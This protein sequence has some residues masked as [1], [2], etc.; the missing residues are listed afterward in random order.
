[1]PTTLTKKPLKSRIRAGDWPWLSPWL[2]IG[3][4]SLL[5]VILT[6]IAF[7]NLHRERRYM[8]T[9]LSA[10]AH[11]LM[12][13]LEAA[14]RT[15]MMGRMGWG[16]NLLQMLMEQ[17]AQEPHV[18]YLR[19]VDRKG[20]V[21]LSSNPQEAGQEMP[22]QSP[23]EAGGHAFSDFQGKKAFEVSRPYEPWAR[24]TVTG[25]G[26]C[27]EDR[28]GPGT[29]MGRG[30]AGERANLFPEAGP[31]RLVV[32]LDATPL[33][34]ALRQDLAHNA[35]LLSIL[36]LL[37]ATGLIALFWAHGY[38]LA[39]QSLRTMQVMTEAIFARMPVGLIATD[40]HGIIRRTNPAARSLLGSRVAPGQRLT[41]LPA[42]ES[43]RHRLQNGEDPI[44]DNIV[45]DSER[46]RPLPLL[47]HATAIKDP[48]GD[49]A[50]FA[51]LLSDMTA[52]H[53]LEQKLRRHERLAALGKLA[54]GVAHEIRNPLSS[55]KGFAAIL[56]RKAGDDPT[57]QDVARTMTHE[58]D[59][60]NRVISEL[61]EFARPAELDPK[62]VRLRDIIQH[63][64]KLVE[65]DAHH[66]GVRLGVEIVPPDLEAVL[67]ADRFAQVLLNLYLNAIQAMDRGG[68][69]T[70]RASM[71]QGMLRVS[72]EDSGPGIAPEALGHI[73]DPYF[74]TK[75]NGVGLGL[76]IVHKIVEAH[77]GEIFVDGADGDG[78]RFV[79][80]I[81]Q[82][83]EA[84][85]HHR[86]DPRDGDVG[87]G[88]RSQPQR[89]PIFQ[90]PDGA[91]REGSK[92]RTT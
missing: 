68:S 92:P 72:V 88:E 28:G 32:G 46:E 20:R 56:A 57:A 62:P 55:I 39:R 58:V 41:D 21:I 64:L 24:C 76:S 23:A 63:S 47:I 69:L 91:C 87:W 67:D 13:S 11:M 5:A 65:K 75:P 77:G 42:L 18:L 80:R 86:I 81:P 78:T 82:R 14:S 85:A 52:V 6:V 50:G 48:G 35:L 8:E 73:F 36:F 17:T 30:S 84:A 38:R 29:G 83:E 74:T 66:A 51:F 19:L 45:C 54:S 12:E 3:S 15:G 89:N 16:R 49:M 90:T 9:S 7:R 43:L 2:I 22:P 40:R 70:V 1:M 71:D 10:Q 33:Q 31:L 26:P 34:E 61:L 27:S 44:E 53:T 60:L 79:I 25:R 59:R 37:G 4:V